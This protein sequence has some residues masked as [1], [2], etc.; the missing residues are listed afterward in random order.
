MI[1][2]RKKYPLR[3]LILSVFVIVAVLLGVYAA[4]VYQIYHFNSGMIIP[5]GDDNLIATFIP[6]KDG[7]L[8]TTID[9]AVTVDMGSRHCY[10]TTETLERLKSKGHPVTEYPTLIYTTGPAGKYHIYTRKV[11]L[12]VELYIHPDSDKVITFDNVELLIWDSK[13]GNIL[14]MDFL[15]RFVIERDTD[16]GYISLLRHV[17]DGYS[18]VCDIN[19]HDSTIGDII[20]YSRRVYIPLQV[21][22][23]APQNYYF[24]TGR[25]IKSCELVQPL[26]NATRATTTV[27]VDSVTGLLT[28]DNCRV[29]VG[30]RMRFARV[31][32][33]DS[34]HT[35]K[36]SIN[37]FRVFNRSIVMD[38]PHRKLYYRKV[39]ETT[40][41][42]PSPEEE[43]AS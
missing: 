23:E 14:G 1:K 31:T 17:P 6:D 4:G 22:D 7:L 27:Y 8:Y 20:G 33:S 18:Y 25:G 36:Y 10:I 9:Q 28:Q 13:E 41:S 42:T 5:E 32:Y 29:L 2:A 12:P 43:S 34:L 40:T 38:L 37:P 30:D 11:V 39:H 15:E 16:T 19:G 21:N 24:D 35:D 26:K 3:T